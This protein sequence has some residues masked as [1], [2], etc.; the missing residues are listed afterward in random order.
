VIH[1]VLKRHSNLEELPVA[2]LMQSTGINTKTTC[3]VQIRYHTLGKIIIRGCDLYVFVCSLDSF[4][5]ATAHTPNTTRKL[6][7]MSDP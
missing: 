6:V 5:T 3:C 1:T 4:P 2:V 7:I